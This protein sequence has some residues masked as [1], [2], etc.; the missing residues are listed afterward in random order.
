MAPRK[1]QGN[2][3]QGEGSSSG[4]KR[5]ATSKDSDDYKKRRERNNI[6]VRKSRQLS[7]QKAKAMEEKM[8]QLRA[9]NRSLEEKVK[10]LSKELGIL[11]DLFLSA[12]TP[13]ATTSGEEASLAAG[14]TSQ[15]AEVLNDVVMATKDH[16]YSASTWK[17]HS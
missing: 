10:L 6:A 11:K 1:Q 8:S 3:G 2:D 4:S 17:R 9:E 13:G 5:S 15:E 14:L 7:R 16:K 12:A